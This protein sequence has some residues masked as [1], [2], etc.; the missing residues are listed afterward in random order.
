MFGVFRV[1]F[2]LRNGTTQGMSCGGCCP[3]IHEPCPRKRTRVWSA[4]SDDLHAVSGPKNQHMVCRMR[5]LLCGSGTNTNWSE[6]VNT[7]KTHKL[8]P[9]T[10][11]AFGPLKCF[12]FQA[13]A[14]PPWGTGKRLCF[15]WKPFQGPLD[16]SVSGRRSLPN[17]KHKSTDMIEP[18]P[19]PRTLHPINRLP[20]RL[21]FKETKVRNLNTPDLVNRHTSDKL[22]GPEML[23]DTLHRRDVDEGSHS[24]S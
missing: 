2:K 4:V 16:L 13:V 18:D 12:R 11:N 17:Q 9:C 24:Y 6:F 7:P 8:L 14:A 5:E 19:K 10:R 21:L 20:E 3:Q 23:R 1:C 22:K 15:C